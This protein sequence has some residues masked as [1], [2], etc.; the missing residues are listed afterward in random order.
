M[1]PAKRGSL[2]PGFWTSPLHWLAFGFGSGASPLAPGT[3]GT[4]VAVLLY[5][6]A[7]R[8]SPGIYL[9]LTAVMFIAGIGICGATARKLGLHDHGGIVWDEITGFFVTMLALPAEWIWVVS[10]FL[11]FRLLDIWKPWPIGWLDRQVSGGLGIMLDDLVAG[12]YASLALQFA[13]RWP[14]S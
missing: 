14:F 4:L 1:S 5:C 11:L 7:A 13:S 12:L 2:P 9:A 6:L 10:G 8:L 3:A